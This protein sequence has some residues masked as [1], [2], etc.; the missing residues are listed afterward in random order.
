MSKFVTETGR[1]LVPE[2]HIVAMINNVKEKE[3]P[4]GYIVYEWSFEAEEGDKAKHFSLSM[5]SSQMAELLR[6][7]GAVEVSKNKFNWESDDVI[8]NTL[9]FNI[10]HVADKKGV[11]REQMSDIKLLTLAP[12]KQDIAWGEDAP[13]AP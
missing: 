4:G 10:V 9:E 7:L 6:V 2:G 1:T 12:V 8:G 11:L 13:S 3:I 5:F